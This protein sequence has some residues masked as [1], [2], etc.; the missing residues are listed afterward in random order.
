[1]IA[2]HGSSYIEENELEKFKNSGENIDNLLTTQIIHGF[3]ASS[4]CKLV[5]VPEPVEVL[6]ERNNWEEWGNFKKTVL[7]GLYFY[8]I[9]I[10][11]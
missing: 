11:Y 5:S 9:Y 8:L 6:R 7:K 10:R 2:K 3:C 4:R 1:M